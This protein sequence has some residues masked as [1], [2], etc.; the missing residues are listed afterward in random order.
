VPESHG[1]P[2]VY[3][4]KVHKIFTQTGDDTSEY[5]EYVGYLSGKDLYP[6]FNFTKFKEYIQEGV[7]GKARG[8]YQSGSQ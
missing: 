1:K 8:I 7:E 5:A 3:R 6:D 2:T 4:R